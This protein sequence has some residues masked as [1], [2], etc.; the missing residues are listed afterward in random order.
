[1]EKQEGYG[2]GLAP[3]LSCLDFAAKQGIEELTYYGFTVD[4]CK[5]PKAQVEAFK[6]ACVEAVELLCKRGAELFVF[7]NKNS[8]LFS[9]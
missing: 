1:M 4:N 5:R 2:Y 3:G 7:G 8:P 9:P 6:R